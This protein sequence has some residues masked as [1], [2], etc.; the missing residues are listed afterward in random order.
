MELSDTF[1]DEAY[2]NRDWCI[3]LIPDTG[4]RP[5]GR[6]FL[7]LK[8]VISL[9]DM[10]AFE[11]KHH[12]SRN[13]LFAAVALLGI[14]VIEKKELVMADWIFHDRTDE[15]KK[16]AFGCLFR[17]IT[18]GLEINKDMKIGEFFKALS[19]KSNA[20]LAHC[21]YEWSIKQDNVYEHD[22]LIV[23]YE[24]NEIMSTTDIGSIGGTRLN[25]TSHAPVNS[26][27]L[28]FQI[29]ETSEGIVPY[30]MFN[31][32]LYSEEKISRTVD[33]FTELLDRLMNSGEDASI[34]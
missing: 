27:S 8:Q 16:N 24:T 21:S 23:C 9:E 26:R 25:V 10:S 30:L 15:V 3:N 13:L 12:L 22:T 11:Q 4:N 34:I 18:I 5:S 1:L 6:T 20:M 2:N 28:A 32:A 33:T 7:P 29:I 17:Y 14:A 31:Q 19:D